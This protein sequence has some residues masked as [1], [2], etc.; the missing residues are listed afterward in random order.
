MTKE[1]HNQNL[2]LK[3]RV[4]EHRRNILTWSLWEGGNQNGYD[5]YRE[6]EGLPEL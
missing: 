1:G 6:R 3:A 5:G 4:K 2:S